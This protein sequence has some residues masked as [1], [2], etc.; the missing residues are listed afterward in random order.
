MG[1]YEATNAYFHRDESWVVSWERRRSQYVQSYSFPNILPDGWEGLKVYSFKKRQSKG[2]HFQNFSAALRAVQ[3]CLY[4]SNL[5]PKPMV[6]NCWSAKQP[7]V[8]MFSCPWSSGPRVLGSSGPR[9][10]GSS[11]PRVPGS[12]GP[13]SSGPRV[14]CS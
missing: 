12:S 10:L 4:T 14:H 8:I 6:G 5:L 11:G 1:W 7:S 13:R 2:P 3:H 9:V